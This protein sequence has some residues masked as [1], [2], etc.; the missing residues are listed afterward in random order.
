MSA[1]FVPADRPERFAKAAAA[2]AGIVI[3]DLEDAVA[4]SAK[5]DALSMALAGIAPTDSNHT[6][7]RALIRVNQVGSPEHDAEVRELLAAAKIPGS[8]LLGFVVPKAEQPAEV[9]S[10]RQRMPPHFALIPLIESAEGL[11][12]SLELARVPGVTR[13]AFGA[14]DYALDINSGNGDRFLDHAR[15]QLVLVSRAAGI[16]APLD[17]PSTDISDGGKVRDSALLARNFGFGG[18]LC[19]HPNQVN[20]VH[21][22]FRPTPSE[23]EWATAVL[24]SSL[25]GASQLKG[26]MI[27]RPVIARAQRIIQNTNKEQ[28]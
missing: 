26:Q 20:V 8:G 12:N 9:Q 28:Q 6:T 22:A 17:S 5:A 14:I 19:I 25:G 21:E 15:A 13:L 2:G 11:V 4:S 3:I 16:A 23:I 27:D 24:G 7:V 18:K 1:L 10:L